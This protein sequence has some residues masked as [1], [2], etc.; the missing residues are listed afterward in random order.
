MFAL[1]FALGLT[2]GWVLQSAGSNGARGALA[3]GPELASQEIAQLRAAVSSVEADRDVAQA[4]LERVETALEAMKARNEELASDARQFSGPTAAA[5]YDLP[6][7]NGLS[8]TLT[9]VVVD[10]P[11]AIDPVVW[12][13]LTVRD[14]APATQV[15]IELGTCSGQDQV[16]LGSLSNVTTGATGRL[17]HVQPNLALPL[18]DASLWIRLSTENA[19]EGPGV[20]A[21]VQLQQLNEDAPI[22]NAGD[23]PCNPA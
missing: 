6:A 23:D 10:E 19:P 16:P 21:L 11:A 2:A 22:M 20:R 4:E 3:D 7:A 8:A 9:F 5:T 17:T 12:L 15:A 18:D 13:L 14:S 1:V